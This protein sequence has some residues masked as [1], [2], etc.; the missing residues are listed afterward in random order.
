MTPFLVLGLPRSRTA[1][2]ARFLSYGD[3][4][5]GHE[6]LRH[7]RSMGDV[8]TWLFQPCIGSCETAAAP[9]WRLIPEG[10][11][12]V[13]VRRAPAEVVASLMAI[14]GLDFNEAMLARVV[15]RLDHKLDQIEARY[16]GVLS[17][18]YE[19]LVQEE[20]CA[21]VFEHCLPYAHDPLWWASLSPINIQCDI[22][23]MMRHAVAFAPAL[24]SL[25]RVAK[26][27][28]IAAMTVNPAPNMDAM[29][30][31]SESFDAW[32]RD[33]QALIDDHLMVVGEAPGDQNTK[34]L[35]LMHD[36]SEAGAMQ[37]VTARSNGR[38]FGY[39]MTLLAPALTGENR[40]SGSNTTFY[41]SPDCPG[42]G[43][44][45]QREAIAMLKARGVHDVFLEA[46]KRGDGPR[47]GTL[48][49]RLGAQEHGTFYRLELE[50]A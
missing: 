6:E 15:R 36:L 2:L 50:A 38:M 8:K 40:M 12:V 45:I 1:W 19:H 24:D 27:K 17:V 48:Y 16:P 14:P 22:R 26:A 10:T 31:Q 42:L 9:F 34:N 29:T 20:T 3:W 23:A 43:V 44:R 5:C 41:A 30:F 33:A 7:M 39:L 37:I 47:L 25:A 4:I 13:T 21:S 18:R 11:R 46:G 28:S 32:Y 49:R 35:K